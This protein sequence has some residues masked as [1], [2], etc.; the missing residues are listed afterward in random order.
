LCWP[1]ALKILRSPEGSR[2]ERLSEV[3]CFS[4]FMEDVQDVSTD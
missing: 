2:E 3:L 1:A 4:G